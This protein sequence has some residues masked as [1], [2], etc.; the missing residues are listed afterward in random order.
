MKYALNAAAKSQNVQLG[1]PIALAG[2]SGTI[3]LQ[4]Q[5]TTLF[6]NLITDIICCELLLV[7]VPCACSHLLELDYHTCQLLLASCS[8]Q[9]LRSMQF[10]SNCLL[11]AITSHCRLTCHHPTLSVV[12]C[13][14]CQTRCD[15]TTGPV[16]HAP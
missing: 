4:L 9:M 12:V 8:C 7:L 3:T 13:C 15:C 6:C 2:C 11:P 1:S 10:A 14:S 5:L 16:L